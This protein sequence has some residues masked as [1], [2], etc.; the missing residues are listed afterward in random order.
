MD[1]ILLVVVAV[2]IGFVVWLLTTR[3]PMPPAWATTI[4]VAALILVILWL[5]S[6]FVAMPNILPHG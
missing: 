2:A 4:Q 6:R 1:L 3:I 5:V